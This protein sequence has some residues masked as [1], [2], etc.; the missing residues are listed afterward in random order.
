MQKVFSFTLLLTAGW[1]FTAAAQEPMMNPSG[2]KENQKPKYVPKDRI[3][4]IEY[5]LSNARIEQIKSILKQYYDKHADLEN[6]D[7]VNDIRRDIQKVVPL[8][9]AKKA[10]TRSPYDIKDSLQSKVKEKYGKSPDEIR[11]SAE[12]DAE[13]KYPMAKRNEVVKVY[14][15]RGRSVLSFSG[16]YYG[17]G[18][19]G[20]SVR[21]N[22]RNIP[23]FDLLPESKS[24]FDKNFNAEMRK[25]FIDE[26]IQDYNKER[27]QYAEKLFSKEYNRIR[28]QN[29]NLGY[30]YQSGN[31]ETAESVLKIHLAEM[32]KKAKVRA[33]LE[34][35]E[36]E[37]QAKNKREAGGNPDSEAKKDN[38]ETENG[39]E[40]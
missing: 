29:E 40:D 18:L 8:A 37:A 10:D 7:V 9:P 39:D 34:R 35:I 25:N 2:N 32:I 12:K 36:K 13:V 6:A 27:L 11:K 26:K 19:G 23:V 21:L 14:Y 15:K 24:L 30:I 31:W 17:F 38:R 4:S 16:H 1:L 22:S 28:K 33:E 20:K 3:T 5:K